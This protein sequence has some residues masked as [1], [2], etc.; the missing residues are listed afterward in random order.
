MTPSGIRLAAL[1][2]QFGGELI[3]DPDHAIVS[4]ATLRSASATDV[5]FCHR[6]KYLDDLRHSLAGVVI[7][8][9]GD[10]DVYAGNR[11][12]ADNP[13]LYF[14]RVSA[15]LNPDPK[16][17][18]G[19]DSSSRVHPTARIGA[20]AAIGPF[21]SIGAN[22]HIDDDVAI[23]GH[24]AI[25]DHVAIGAGTRIDTRVSI[26]ARSVVGKR[27]VILSG[28]V[29]GADG[30]GFAPDGGRWVK[31]PQVGRVV[32]GDDVEIGAN[33]TIDRG[34]LDD[35]IIEEGVKLDNQ[36]Q[37]GHNCRIG[38]HTAIAGCV[39]IAGSTRLGQRC[40]IGGAAMIAGHLE[41]GDGV[42]VSGGTLISK[43]IREA[44]IYTGV[45]PFE[46]NKKWTRNA[47]A[48]RHLEDMKDR[49]RALERRFPDPKD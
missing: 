12:V 26:Y 34:A 23:G 4:V 42:I 27:C 9:P 46:Q 36:V 48:L 24:C 5:S 21:C 40:M 3:G 8:A 28:A 37:I 22:C 13:Y 17:A 19:I 2:E 16:P 33:T 18:L 44:G 32:L 35:T 43:S 15:L 11:I 49:I 14:A 41:L 25:G 39:G 30:F 10:R 7:V 45:Y 6:G 29:I 47:A 31:I 20:G 38:A 1:I